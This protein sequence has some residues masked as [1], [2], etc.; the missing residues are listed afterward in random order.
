MSNPAITLL[1]RE[2][3]FSD[4]SVATDQTR[5]GYQ[6]VGPEA[7]HG[8][9]GRAQTRSFFIAQEEDCLGGYAEGKSATLVESSSV[10]SEA[11]AVAEARITVAP[12]VHS[13]DGV[14]ADTEL[15]TAHDALRCVGRE[16]EYR[17]K[18]EELSVAGPSKL[19]FDRPGGR[20]RIVAGE[21]R[22]LRCS[23]GRRV[24]AEVRC[25][26][27]QQKHQRCDDLTRGKRDP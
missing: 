17:R 27:E 3:L 7:I 4:A 24:S 16:L 15:H 26:P 9:C 18:P 6:A 19:H 2:G 10:D 21:E 1:W 12:H 20:G 5:V 25:A 14:E 23:L 8:D 22:P 11:D 13:R